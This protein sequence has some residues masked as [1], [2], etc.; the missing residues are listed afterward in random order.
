M[1][2]LIK[3]N[4]INYMPTPHNSSDESEVIDLTNEN[5]SDDLDTIDFGVHLF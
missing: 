2:I 5:T 1:N 3:L 4:D